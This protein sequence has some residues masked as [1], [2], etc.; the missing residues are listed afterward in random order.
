MIKEMLEVLEGLSDVKTKWTPPEGTFAK[1][2]DPK[3]SAEVIC[4]GHKG[5]LESAVAS[6]NYFFNR[7]G[8]NCK[9]W[10]LKDKLLNELRKMCNSK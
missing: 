2:A 10:N 6:V 5:D 3:K 7:C 4:K 8:D 9:D 1:D